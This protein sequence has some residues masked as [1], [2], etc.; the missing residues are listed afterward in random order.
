VLALPCGRA[1]PESIRVLL[2]DSFVRFDEISQHFGMRCGDDTGI[3]VGTGT[4]IVE[5][6]SRDSAGD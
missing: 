5:Y 6:S 2:L 4:E 1:S 3:D